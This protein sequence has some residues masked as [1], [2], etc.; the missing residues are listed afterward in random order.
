MT[1]GWEVLHFMKMAEKET[2]TT[3]T[4][5][6]ILLIFPG[7]S[8]GTEGMAVCIEAKVFN[9]IFEG[10]MKGVTER[11]NEYSYTRIPSQHVY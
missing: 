7:S 6:A 11:D 5:M 2:A 9:C 10:A 1:K 3:A 4:S 8:G